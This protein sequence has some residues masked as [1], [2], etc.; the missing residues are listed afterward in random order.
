[1][2]HGATTLRQRFHSTAGLPAIPLPSRPLLA[3]T[4]L[5]LHHRTYKASIRGKFKSRQIT[6]RFSKHRKNRFKL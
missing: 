1:M 2:E 4:S 6:E 3:G 5:S